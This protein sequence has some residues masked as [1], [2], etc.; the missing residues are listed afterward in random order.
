MYN[1]ID[2][3]RSMKYGN[4]YWEVYSTKIGRNIKLYSDLEYDNWV[5]IEADP[6]IVSFCEQPIKIEGEYEGKTIKS[7]FDMWVLYDNGTEEFIEVK[8]EADL[9]GTSKRC[10]RTKRQIEIQKQWCI[11]NNY[12]Y[13]IKT[14]KEIRYDLIYLNNLKQIIYQV[15]NVSDIDED[16]ICK[17][18]NCIKNK[19]ISIKQLVKETKLNN[20]YIMKII[21]KLIYSGVCR[22]LNPNVE[23]NLDSEV[24]LIV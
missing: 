13:R 6:N 21:C 22:L 12:N 19:N 4:N 3:K 9:K 17:V 23:L 14:D 18:I 20:G 16:D 24:Y 2:I 10:E 5:T 8:Y 7:I 15:R 11:N 1:P